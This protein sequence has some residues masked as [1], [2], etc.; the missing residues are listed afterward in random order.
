MKF[1][2]TDYD[3]IF[4][5]Y[6][7][8]N[9]DQNYEDLLT[10]FPWAKRVHGVKGSDAAHKA[11]ADLSDTDRFIIVDADNIVDQAFL[12]HEYELSDDYDS[13]NVVLSWSAE[14]IINGLRYGNGSIKCWTKN[15][16]ANMRTHEAA[17]K[18]NIATQVD[19]CWELQYIG[20]PQVFS[21][22]H[23]NGS[24][25]QA[26]RAG[27]R[28]GVKLA[29]HEG[30]KLTKYQLLNETIDN[31]QRLCMWMMVGQDVENGMWSIYG[32]R[33]GLAKLMLTDWD[34]TRVRDFDYLEMLWGDIENQTPFYLGEEIKGLG[35]KLIDELEIPIG[36]KALS[37]SHSIFAKKVWN[38]PGR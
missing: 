26:W 32:A 34:Y 30:Q 13:D 6:D 11:C 22:V 16:I 19:F 15:T 35:R 20:I 1:K 8:P 33:Q 21:K 31:L 4:L 29:L 3:I 28:E 18:D 10:K 27:F 37:A 17:D 2:I 38:D 25:Y 9:A 12:H 24:N 23:N 7:E 5:S 36:E 14:N